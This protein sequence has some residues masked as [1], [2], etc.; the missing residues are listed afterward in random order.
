MYDAIVEAGMWLSTPLNPM[1]FPELSYNEPARIKI[2]ARSM[3]HPM[4]PYFGFAYLIIYKEG[5]G[6]PFGSISNG[7]PQLN[8]NNQVI[9][10]VSNLD[11]QNNLA[12]GS[13]IVKQYMIRFT[14]N[15]HFNDSVPE[16]IQA[17]CLG[18]SGAFPNSQERWGYKISQTATQ[19]IFITFVS[20]VKNMLGQELG[21]RPCPIPEARIVYKYI[22]RPVVGSV[23]Q[24][25]NPLSL[26]NNIGIF[27][28]HLSQGN[29]S[30]GFEWRDSNNIH[31]HKLTRLGQNLIIVANLIPNVSHLAEYFTVHFRAC[32]KAGCS[33]WKRFRPM[34][35]SDPQGCPYIEDSYNK[36]RWLQ[37]SIL[38]GSKRNPGIELTDHYLYS[39]PLN[40]NNELIKFRIVENESD[41]TMI[42]KIQMSQILVDRGKEAGVTLEGEPFS[43][44]IDESKNIARLNGTQDVTD[45]LKANDNEL[46]NLKEDDELNIEF[47]DDG[48]RYVILRMRTPANKD[49]VAAIL[50]A[51]SEQQF[52]IFSRGYM[53]TICLK[54]ETESFERI[55]L[56]AE[57]DIDVDQ[58]GIVRNL[59]DFELKI[60]NMSEASN[61]FGDVRSFVSSADEL[62]ITISKDNPAS[63]TFENKHDQ[64]KEAYFYLSVTGQISIDHHKSEFTDEITDNL[65]FKLMDNIP[66]PFNPVTKI[67]FQIPEAGNVNL[68]I[69]DISGREVNTLVNEFKLPGTY[70]YDFDGSSLSSGVYFYRLQSNKNIATKRMII[71][72]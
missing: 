18:N 54:V 3:T 65:E 39:N 1:S 52:K 64:D 42:N 14:L 8:L 15:G 60:L 44:V 7:N 28:G 4:F 11:C 57:Q 13:Y 49:N 40:K 66:N 17:Y 26:A 71:I 33:E 41:E 12:T 58:I 6:H 62:S 19:A 32:N 35:G 21:F 56:K 47:P 36:I 67:R 5:A 43:F 31:Q 27:T 9:Q 23:T 10:Y 63:F 55:T 70:Q 59:N 37:N 72:K 34:F 50:T 69:F 53:S 30:I 38:P 22:R 48:S 29:D 46:L 68:S 16:V 20:E 45:L 24:Q 61:K 2:E 25:P 51:N